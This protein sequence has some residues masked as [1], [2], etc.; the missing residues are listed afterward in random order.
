[1]SEEHITTKKELESALFS[2]ADALRSKMDA[3]EYKNYLLGIVFYKYLSDKMLYHIGEVLVSKENLSL[4][5]SLK[6]YIENSNDEDL[7]DDLRETFSYTI[8]PEHTFTYI[9]DEI[10]GKAKTKE[11]K[12]KTFQ[13]S[14]LADAFNDIE[15]SK[16]SDFDGLFADVQ[17]YSPRLGTNAQKQA[18]TIANVIKAIGNLEFVKNVDKH[19]T[20]GDAYEYLI[21]QFASETGKKA[22]EFYTPQQ[23]SE[24]LT[25]LT[26]IGKNYPDEMTVYDPAMGFRVIIVIEANSY[27]NIRSSRLLPKFKTQKINSWCAA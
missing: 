1:M 21:G 22:G 10:N 13:I 6:L 27:V 14:D 9:L 25:K 8:S 23:V 11:G 4:E 12:L 5:E 20:L 26:L 3:N 19:D 7:I 18:D 2:A 15:S 24:L 16:N 17:L